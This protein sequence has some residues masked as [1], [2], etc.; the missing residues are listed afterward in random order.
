[1]RIIAMA[2]QKGGV[3]KTTTSFNVAA[4]LQIRGLK[5]LLI[6]LD[7]QANL[8]TAV[9]I[10]AHQLSDNQTVLGILR[11]K[12]PAQS[13]IIE[14]D[15]GL[16]II[17]SNIR[18]SMADISLSSML[19][20]ERLL[21]DALKKIKGYDVIIIDCPPALSLLNINAFTAADTV[22][23]PV[24]PEMMGV[25]GVSLLMDTIESMKEHLNP[26]LRVGGIIITL[27]EKNMNV[28]K[29]SMKVLNKQF[30][31]LICKTKIRKNI[32]LAESPIFR[33]S[34][35]VYDYKSIGAK[36]YGDLVL[37]IMEREKLG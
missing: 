28:V 33:Q 8:T 27:Y 2:N 15:M 22:Y 9:G 20:R 16:D 36:D 26:E 13:T 25:Q 4:G 10:A 31:E 5:T 37:E 34:I 24:Q 21:L 32:T 29:E 23:I 3:A 18:L 14:T 35:F 19:A 17:P 6:D 12:V 30:G 1:M 11:D 7:S